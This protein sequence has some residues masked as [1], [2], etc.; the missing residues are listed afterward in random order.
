LPQVT[1]RTQGYRAFLNKDDL[2]KTRRMLEQQVIYAVVWIDD[3][4]DEIDLEK[5][6]RLLEQ[7]VIRRILMLS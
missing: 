1:F 2:E 5:T 3:S 7:Q 6:R 4:S